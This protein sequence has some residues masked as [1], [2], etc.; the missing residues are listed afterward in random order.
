MLAYEDVLEG[1]ALPSSVGGKLASPVFESVAPVFP[2]VLAI[3]LLLE[4][5]Y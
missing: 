2:R 4:L 1:F 5:A 3:I